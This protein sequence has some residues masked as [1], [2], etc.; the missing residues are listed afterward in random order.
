MHLVIR[1]AFIFI[2]AFFVGIETAESAETNPPKVAN[3]AKKRAAKP[4]GPTP[5]PRT[6]YSV[7]PASF[8]VFRFMQTDQGGRSSAFLY[9]QTGLNT[10]GSTF[11]LATLSFRSDPQAQTVTDLASFNASLSFYTPQLSGFGLASAFSA[12]G[13]NTD[14]W[15]GGP[16]FA[17]LDKF[18]TLSFLL[19][20]HLLFTTA[21]EDTGRFQTL[22]TLSYAGGLIA[23]TGSVT[24]SWDN[25]NEQSLTT[26]SVSPVV[27]IKVY[28][29]LRF[30]LLYTHS[31]TGDTSTTTTGMGLEL[32]QSF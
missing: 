32:N 29:N 28:E 9:N 16:Y 30:A 15:R 23:S 4:K 14:T 7:S 20:S 17:Y 12:T 5:P 6:K 21:S 26:T 11:L 19:A 24:Y 31:V 2:W 27:S 1:I 25:R 13:A 18:G 10:P 8:T 3:S 22:W